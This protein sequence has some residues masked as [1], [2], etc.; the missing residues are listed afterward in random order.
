[1]TRT[2]PLTSLPAH[3]TIERLSAHLDRELPSAEA[4]QID[5][6]LTHCEVCRHRLAG[7]RGVATSVGQLRR[8]APP[9]TLDQTVARRI[10]LAGERVRLVDRFESGLARLNQ[11]ATTWTLLAVILALAIMLFLFSHRLDRSRTSYL[12]V[13][14]TEG[15]LEPARPAETERRQLEGRV[16]LRQGERWVEEG[17][18][19]DAAH[20]SLAAESSAGREFLARS[21]ELAELI[22]LGS[23]VVL[24][25]DGEI[26]ELRP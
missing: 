19:P 11:Q 13:I 10:A 15:S 26:V 23:A 9:P 1:M 2:T 6:H 25:L 12:P 3:P 7:L 24:D 16:F 14:F 20:R 21:P 8:L 4:D 17:V 18:D 22:E 5:E